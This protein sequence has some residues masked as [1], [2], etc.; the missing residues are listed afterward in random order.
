MRTTLDYGSISYMAAAE[1]NLK[2]LEIEQSKAPRICCAFKTSPV[3]S[4]QVEMG[5]M[6]LRLRRWKQMLVHIGLILKVMIHHIQLK[7][8]YRRVGNMKKQIFLVL[9]GLEMYAGLHVI[10][11]C[12]VVQYPCIPHWLFINTSLDLSLHD[13]IKNKN[14]SVSVSYLVQKFINKHLN[15]V[16]LFT[17]GSKDPESG[18]TGAAVH[19]PLQNIELKKK[20][21]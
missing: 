14:K 18:R 19:I 11:L 21:E 8:F 10:D 5:E 17:D 20:K 2:L 16:I 12:P 6:P 3:A 15:K 13:L 4:L 9:A 7:M 1:T